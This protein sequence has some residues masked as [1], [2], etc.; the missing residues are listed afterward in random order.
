M[1]TDFIHTL[2]MSAD[3][4]IKMQEDGNLA[5]SFLAAAELKAGTIVKMIDPMKVGPV[6]AV[7]DVPFG[8]VVTSETKSDRFKVTV[9]TNFQMI[10]RGIA[11]GAITAGDRLAAV[12]QEVVGT[13]PELKMKYKLGV[14]TNWIYAVA[15]YDA[16]DEAEVIVGILK[17]PQFFYTEST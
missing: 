9:Q 17:V 13:D 12:A 16:V 14:A 1:A 8:V 4:V 2:G 3:S 10:V 11:D 7:T 5:V 15:L 6:T